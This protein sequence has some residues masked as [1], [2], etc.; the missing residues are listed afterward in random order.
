M[1]VWYRMSTAA[2]RYWGLVIVASGCLAIFGVGNARAAAAQISIDHVD[3]LWGADTVFA[4]RDIRFYLRYTNNTAYNYIIS[5]GYRIYSPDGAVWSSSRGDTTG[6]LPRSNWD[7]AFAINHFHGASADTIGII[8]AK[9]FGLGLPA[10]FDGVPYTITVGFTDTLSSGKHICIDSSWFRTA[11]TWKWAAS[12]SITTYPS[13]SGPYCYLIVNCDRDNDRICSPVDNCPSVYNPDQKDSDLDG[14][15]DACDNCPSNYNPDQADVDHDGIGDACDPGQVQ[16]TADVRCG[17]APLSVSFTDQSIPT[18]GVTSWR[19]YFGDGGTSNQRNPVHV[20]E[21]SG[22]FDVSLVISDGVGVDSL[23]IPTFITTQDRLTVDFIGTPEK[24]RSPLAVMF[25]PIVQGLANEYYWDFGDG[26]NSAV[27]NPIHTYTTQGI[28]DVKLRVRLQLNACNQADSITKQ[29]FV[30]VNDVQALFAANP[31]AGTMPLTVQF[32][33]TST[34]TPNDW[35]WD[36]GDGGTSTAQN[37]QHTYNLAGRYSVKLRAAY[38]ALKDSL[39]KLDLITVDSS[40]ADVSSEIVTVGAKP[41]FGFWFYACWTNLGTSPAADVVLKVLPPSFMTVSEVYPGWIQVGTFTGYSTVGD[42]LI[43]PLST[44]A[45]SARY[46]GYVRVYGTLAGWPEV[47]VGDTLTCKS[48]LTTT[49]RDCDRANDSAVQSFVV[50]GSID[51]NDKKAIPEGIGLKR[52]ILPT[53]RIEYLVQFENKKEATEPAVY[54]RVVDT[55]DANLDWGSLAMGAMSNPDKCKWTFDPY[56]GIIEW[57]CDSIMLPPNVYP[58]EGEGYFTYSIE[59][60][61]GLDAGT[62]ISNRAHIR[63]DFNKWLSAPESGPVVRTIGYL[64]CCRGL[65]GNVDGDPGDI[66]DISDVTFL[67]DYLFASGSISSCR[68]EN[69]VDKSGSVDISD[70]TALVDY[71]FVGGTLP[72]CP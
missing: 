61:P 33:D 9:V 57:Y 21:N 34:G 55:L 52:T 1:T 12:G 14:I 59:P 60:K 29:G 11:G 72:N 46:G 30:V 64:S 41:G 23:M 39:L 28:Y 24:G 58:P 26:S 15:G 3:G 48:W 44:V 17:S 40:C 47:E 19:W 54:V 50:T 35:Y 43:I 22:V 6:A 7:I 67:V 25:E 18:R 71:L 51:P 53:T 27:R 63:F 10:G 37:P 65:T 2:V 16:F 56:K 45:P 70:L 66:V 36:F 68:E 8:A 32:Q 31:T 49:S 20:Y 42:T 5:N 13:W 69:D 62:E 38:G 4:G